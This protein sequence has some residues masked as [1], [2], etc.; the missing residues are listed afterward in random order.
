MATKLKLFVLR[1]FYNENFIFSENTLIL[2]ISTA[3]DDIA[4]SVAIRNAKKVDKDG[5]RTIGELLSAFSISFCNFVNINQEFEEIFKLE[6]NYSQYYIVLFWWY[7][8]GSK[9]M[10]VYHYNF[11]HKA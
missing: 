4:N 2:A 5:S 10:A 8:K 3:T 9:I 1:W 6:S 7:L 11:L